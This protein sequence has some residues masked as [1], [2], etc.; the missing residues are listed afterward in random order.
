MPA[1][2][3]QQCSTDTVERIASCS[4]FDPGRSVTS[5]DLEF[6]IGML[7]FTTP[8]TPC[9]NFASASGRTLKVA[10]EGNSHRGTE[11]TRRHRCRQPRNAP[12]C[13]AVAVVA[14][15][16]VA[17]AVA[18]CCSGRRSLRLPRTRRVRLTR[19]PETPRVRQLAACF[20]CVA[21]D[22]PESVCWPSSS[23][24]SS[25]SPPR[26]TAT[27]GSENEYTNSSL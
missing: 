24:S 2:R 15:A 25:S 4:T 18:C 19:F 16:V 6:Q 9:E 12:S 13:N 23:S 8:K 17:V 10:P 1:E 14:V 26:A 7:S 20:T 3:S 22:A 27:V 5:T 21:V 11:S